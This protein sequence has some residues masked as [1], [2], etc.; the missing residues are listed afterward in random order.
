M[1]RLLFV[2]FFGA[3][4]GSVDPSDL[5]IRH[6]ELAGT[7]ASSGHHPEEERAAHHPT[8]WLMTVPVANLDSVLDPDRVARLRRANA[9]WQ[10]FFPIRMRERR[11]GCHWASCFPPPSFGRRCDRGRHRVPALR[12][13]GAQAGAVERFARRDDP[14]A[15]G[16]RQRVLLRCGVRHAAGYGRRAR[17]ARG[18]SASSIRT[19]STPRCR[20]VAISAQW[21]GSP[22]PQ[23][24]NGAGFARTRSRSR[25][26]S[27]AS[28]RTMR[29]HSGWADESSPLSCSV[30]S[31]SVSRSTPS[32]ANG[33]R[34]CASSPRRSRRSRS[35]SRSTIRRPP[36]RRSAGSRVPSPRRSIW[37][38]DRSRS[39][40]CCCS[41]S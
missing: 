25:S 34:W 11:P 29:S 19:S 17:S 9:P 14:Y 28:S 39:G 5:G 21:L 26:A 24:P 23:L 7:S 30:R 12:T 36:T 2:T 13:R 22:V 32:R 6:P 20:E 16:A 10:H 38:S 31:W 27:S 8:S 41:R 1:F 3:Y 35:C 37:A 40:S 4:R 15:R 33:L 18:S